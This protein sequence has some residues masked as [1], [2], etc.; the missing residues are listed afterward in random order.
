MK[1]TDLNPHWV[2]VPQVSYVKLY[3]GITFRCPHCPVG[4]RGE[5]FYIGIFFANPVDPDNWLPRITPL[6][7]LAEHVW[8]R[9]GDTFETLSLTPSVDASKYGHW[10]GFLH[11]GQLVPV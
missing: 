11:N 1:L 4:E 8:A 10:H 2:T 9:T 3:I 7:K 5:V 6:G